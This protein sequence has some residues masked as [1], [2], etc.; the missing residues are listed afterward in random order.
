[1]KKTIVFLMLITLVISMFT[2]AS[3]GSITT[4]LQNEED[5][6]I[7][8]K[9]QGSDGN[10]PANPET[11]GVSPTTGL[12]FS[13]TYL[14]MLVQIDNENGG[15]GA[16]AP[17]GA[18]LADIIYETPLHKNG[19]TRLSFLFSDTIPESVGPV[20]SA[21]VT[22]A[23][24]REEWDA[25]FV[26]Y[27]GQENEGTNINDTFKATGADQKGVLFSGIVGDGKPWKK[28]Y[29]RVQ[30]LVSPHNV[31]A[32]VKA[33]QA[34]IPSDFK[35]PS[36]PFLYTDELPEEGDLATDIS[37]TRTLPEYSSSFVYDPDAN[38]Y[39]RFVNGQPYVD[40]DT[41]DQLVFSNLIIQRTSV[42]YYH[43]INDRPVTVD[44]GSG[45]ADI[46]LGGR[47]IPGYWVRTGMNQRTVFF[48]QD[49]NEIQLQRGKTFISM[50]DYGTNVTYTAK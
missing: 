23:E 24:L 37:I 48:D 33:M 22:H 25:G 47:Y 41:N 18:S 34:L 10:F 36:R 28:F 21:R 4:A 38:V 15:I 3:A 14:P 46:F 8:V 49:G 16:R 31:N 29:S 39:A 26:F 6:H 5:R 2:M 35:A 17:W 42:T 9:G 27:G 7:S 12:P 50:L 32:N 13:G 1:M 11:N 43:D 45:N 20:R 19:N 30:K 44:I 40:K